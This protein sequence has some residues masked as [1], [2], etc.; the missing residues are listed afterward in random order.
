[1]QQSGI[2]VTKSTSS[3]LMVVGFVSA[4]SMSKFDIAKLLVSNIQDPI[5]G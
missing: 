1:V 5:T 3:F 4:Y 2:R